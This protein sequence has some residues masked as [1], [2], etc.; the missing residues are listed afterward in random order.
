MNRT[1][2]TKT[3]QSNK[4][5][6][7]TSWVFNRTGHTYG[8]HRGTHAPT[9][10]DTMMTAVPTENVYLSCDAR[11][12]NA[13]RHT[14]TRKFT[15]ASPHRLGNANPNGHANSQTPPQIGECESEGTRK[16]T[17]ASPHRLWNANPK[18]HASSQ[19]QVPTDCGM[20]IRRDTQIHKRKSPQIG[21]CESEGT[22][23]FTNAS[24]HRLGNANPN[25][26]ASS[27]RQVPT[28][29]G[30]RIRRDTQIH[31][32]KS[33]QIG[34]CESEWTHKFTNASPHRLGNANPN[35]HT[36]SQTQAPTEWGMR[37]RMRGLTWRALASLGSPLRAARAARDRPARYR[38][39]EK[40]RG[41]FE[42]APP[43]PTH[44]H[45]PHSPP[46]R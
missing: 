4:R 9:S 21:E 19:T 33:P 40:T 27:Q 15:N 5:Q 16:F 6:K 17:N 44:T 36:N 34:E 2:N 32:R 29:C 35:G 18:G 7:L 22:H 13:R 11:T 26:H 39:S 3:K 8:P 10:A 42:H 20:R 14:G 38:I 12:S 31:K 24:P 41:S 43:P 25:G 28:D 23:K 46:R 30:M 37:I 45:L 1:Q